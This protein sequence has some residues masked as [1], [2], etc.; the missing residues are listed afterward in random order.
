MV[1]VHNRRNRSFQSGWMLLPYKTR[2]GLIS[3]R[4][5]ALFGEMI[6]TLALA[7]KCVGIYSGGVG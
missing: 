2:K 1:P 3:N 5:E 6:L 4:F 7:Q